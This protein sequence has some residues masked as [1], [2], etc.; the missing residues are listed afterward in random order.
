MIRIVSRDKM[1]P[2]EAAAHVRSGTSLHFMYHAVSVGSLTC[3][4]TVVV[5]AVV[6]SP[7]QN[8][9]HGFSTMHF[10]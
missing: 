9:Q 1:N 5:C 2:D 4:V 8:G 6:V 7:L 10:V 3:T